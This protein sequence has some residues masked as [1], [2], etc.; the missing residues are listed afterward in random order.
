MSRP[1][2]FFNFFA[3]TATTFSNVDPIDLSCSSTFPAIV[4]DAIQV[5]S[6]L[7]IFTKNQQFML[8]TDSDV[9]NPNTAKI[10]AL[11]AYNFNHKT[12]PISLGTT[13]GFLDNA[14]KNSRFFE[15]SNIRREGEP[16]VVNQSQVVSELLTKNLTLVSSSRENN[17]I[18]FSELNTN[19]I[20]AYRYFDSGNKR[21][22]AAWFSWTITGNVIYHCM[23]DDAL[24]VV[25]RNNNKDQLL[26]YS[27]KQDTDGN[28]VTSGQTFTIHLDHAMSVTTASNTYANGKT[29]FPKP[30]GLEST[31]QL[32]AYDADTGNNLGR[33]GKI[34]VNGSNLEL[35]GDW[36]GETFII[37]YLFDMQVE[38]PTIFFGYK[39]GEDF[40]ADTRAD[41][42]VHR[43]KFSFGDIGVYKITLDRD[44]KPQYIEEK[45][46]NRANQQTANTPT[47]LAEDI[48]TIPTYER[49]KNLKV[50]VSSEHPS[51]ATMLSYQW[52]GQYTNKSYKRV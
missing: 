33:Y 2:D 14:G 18:F 25:V 46:V 9:L 28:Y 12:N 20:F 40:R 48:E 4:F 1:G 43:L 38:L 32:V 17:V 22:L 39:D 51:P 37:G 34:T 6:G 7:V 19:K 50:T 21:I 29:T 36:S 47:F 49:N 26:K 16:Q 42:I 41:L 24:H 35:D 3:K 27:I 45:E 15:M 44:G 11:A 30:T 52:E 10:N 31:K 5:N 23:L 8:T 13:I